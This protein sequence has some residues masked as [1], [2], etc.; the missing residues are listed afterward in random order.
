M[1]N[2]PL[3]IDWHQILLHLF[4]FAI[5]S[6]GLYL[7]LYKPVK[8]FM[9]KREAHYKE[10]DDKANSVKAEAE[11]IKQEYLDKMAGLDAQIEQKR[12]D[13]DKEI[14]DMRA[15]QL[16]MVRKE[17]DEILAKARKTAEHEY[18]LMMKNYTDEVK[19]LAISAAQKALLQS[20]G[21]PYDEFIKLAERSLPDEQT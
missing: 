21:D 20:R 15:E 8:D 1:T 2:L 13:A 3:N 6:G 11:R 10:V 4:N 12:M 9:A 5:L 17:A 18:N 7:L 19:E 16:A 14:D